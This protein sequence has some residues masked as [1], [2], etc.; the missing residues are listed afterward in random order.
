MLISV[1]VAALVVH[2]HTARN[3]PA[4]MAREPQYY[5]REG[6]VVNG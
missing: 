2:V 4:W 6:D 1:I 3:E 5:R